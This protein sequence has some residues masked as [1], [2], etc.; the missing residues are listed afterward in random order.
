MELLSIVWDVDPWLVQFGD[1][2]G[3]RWYGLL[4]ASGFLF[5]YLIFNHYFKKD[6]LSTEILDQ[7]T[8]Y[9][10][11]GTIIGARLGHCFFYDFD[12]FIRHPLEILMVWK[13]GLASHG[14]FFGIAIALFLFVKKTGLSLL[15][16]MDRIAV[17]TALAGF[18]IR[19]GNLMNSEIYG[20]ATKLPWGFS[21]VRDRS[22]RA[23]FY[24]PETGE[25]LGQHLPCHPT[26]IY[27]ALSYL[28]IFIILFWAI[29]KFAPKLKE[30]VIFAWFMISV[31]SVRFLIEFL[32]FEQSDFEVNMINKLHINMGQ[33][34]SIPF[35]LLGVG[36]LL[37][38]RKN[39]KLSVPA[40]G[41]KSK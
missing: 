34:L 29:R 35:V 7:L 18:F 9:M 4:F 28:V 6:G 5:G 21:F 39:G 1:S 19:M 22:S 10:A 11:L 14:A 23:N 24:D 32:K 38:L 40:K 25:F 37:W 3:I 33:M 8:I 2:F 15:W 31:F 16:I 20:H 12:Y 13:G 41:S 30:G 27:E 17:V 26:Q 36:V